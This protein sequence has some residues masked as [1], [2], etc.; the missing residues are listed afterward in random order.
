MQCR[1]LVEI[2]ER[3]V[4]LE[5]D[6]GGLVNAT[7]MIQIAFFELEE[8]HKVHNVS[9]E[10]IE[11]IR[12]VT[13]KKLEWY[14][15]GYLKPKVGHEILITEL[16]EFSSVLKALSMD[17]M[18]TLEVSQFWRVTPIDINRT[19]EGIKSVLANHWISTF[20]GKDVE[21]E[22]IIRKTLRQML[23]KL[24]TIS[25]NEPPNSLVYFNNYWDI[26]EALVS[27]N[28]V[29]EEKNCIPPEKAI[30]VRRAA[31]HLED[32]HIYEAYNVNGPLRQSIEVFVMEMH[33]KRSGNFFDGLFRTMFTASSRI[34]QNLQCY[35][36]MY[37]IQSTIESLHGANEVTSRTHHVPN[38]TEK[39]ME[40]IPTLRKLYQNELSQADSCHLKKETIESAIRDLEMPEHLLK[41]H[42]K[43]F[44]RNPLAGGWNNI[45]NKYL[46]MVKIVTQNDIA[47]HVVSFFESELNVE[48]MQNCL[49]QPTENGKLDA[50]EDLKKKYRKKLNEFAEE[51]ANAW[52]AVLQKNLSDMLWNLLRKVTVHGYKDFHDIIIRQRRA[53]MV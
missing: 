13:I 19:Y 31:Y 12:S 37:E 16:I 40:F 1:T 39:P 30:T 24:E 45:G 49:N 52:D 10:G 51:S 21:K 48:E 42:I 9:P 22:A 25:D 2:Y 3:I 34:Q 14:E 15:N 41:V 11:E 27:V 17:D 50:L 46:Q 18:K 7:D 26:R 32:Q 35:R 43:S 28:R 53:R 4:I 23:V 5:G 20:G 6:G 33:I 47:A 36:R 38:I 8:A 29:L 44:L